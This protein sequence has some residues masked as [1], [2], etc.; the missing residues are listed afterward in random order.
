MKL[1]ACLAAAAAAA[2]VPLA[3]ARRLAPREARVLYDGFKVFE[4]DAPEGVDAIIEK[5][6]NIDF[7]DVDEGSPDSYSVAVA[8][9]SVKD[10]EALGLK[11]VVVHEDLGADILLE[12]DLQPYASRKLSR[13]SSEALSAHLP[14]V[15]WFNAYHAYADHVDYIED[16]HYAFSHNSE[17]VIAGKSYEGRD[18][19]GIHLWGKGGKSSKPAI[20]WHS[21]THAR[22]WITTMT[23]EYFLYQLISGYLASDAEV[24]ALLNAY[25]F[26]VLPVV[27]PDGFI[28]SQTTDRLWRKNR[29][30]RC[31]QACIGTDLNRNWPHYWNVT[32]G[33]SDDPCAQSYRGLSPGD[34]PEMASFT[35]YTDK[36]ASAH[37]DGIKFFV[38]WH[39]FGHIILMPYGGNCSLRV[40]NYDRQMELARQ[41]TAIIESVAG[42]KYRY[43]PVCDVLYAASGGS[44]DYVYDIAGADIA[45]GWELS[46]A[47]EAAG[48][49]VLPAEK[50]LA[51]AQENWKGVKWLLTQL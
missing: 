33:A 29:Q 41:T 43:G 46:P 51:T 5:I 19:H 23:V 22:E 2:A 1:L 3:S 36:V 20:Y 14:G 4:I 28:H 45:W 12:G 40:A 6:A 34:T 39:A 37:P 10:F 8:P 13:A 32:G 50:I 17:L 16:L 21:T 25:D 26:Y 47:S 38:D 27:N 7:I 31:N 15:E 9:E 42:S 18:I 44:M 11:H 48:G 30:P 24:T 49:F 35:A